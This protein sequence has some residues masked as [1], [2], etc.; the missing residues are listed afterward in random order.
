MFRNV[1]SYLND[2]ATRDILGID[3]A[4]GNWSSHNNA[5]TARFEAN[6]DRVSFRAEDSIG[7][8]LERGVRALVYV[9]DTD[10][11]CNWVRAFCGAAWTRPLT[12][13]RSGTSA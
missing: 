8:L 12:R 5:V 3:S 2:P 13:A 10:W 4:S 6:A 7:A 1:D 11:I 9:G